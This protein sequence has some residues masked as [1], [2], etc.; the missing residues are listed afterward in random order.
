MHQIVRLAGRSSEAASGASDSEADAPSATQ[1]W[2]SYTRENG[3]RFGMLA[4]ACQVPPSSVAQPQPPS[5]GRTR[6]ELLSVRLGKAAGER[7][8]GVSDRRL[9]SVTLDPDEECAAQGLRRTVKFL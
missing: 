9:N 6:S 4:E 1:C 2:V 3:P 8:D 7:D 5:T